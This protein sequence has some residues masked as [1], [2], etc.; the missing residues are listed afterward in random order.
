MP[1]AIVIRAAGTNCDSEMVRAFRLAG[2]SCDLVHVDRLIDDPRRLEDYELIGFPG[3]FSFGDDVASGRIFALRLKL[4]LYPA[5]R[6]AAR[7]GA[8]MIGACNGF[9]VLTQAGLLPGPDGEWP[10]APPRQEVSLTFNEGGSFIDRWLKVE[11]DPASVCVWTRGLAERFSGS[12]GDEA[13]W[14]PIAHGEGRFVA[15]SAAVL[16]RLQRHGQVALRYGPGDNV[17]GSMDRVAGI[18][19]RSGRIFGLMPHPERYLD[20]NRHPWWTRLDA[21][22]AAGSTPGLAMF[23]NAVSA[24]SRAAAPV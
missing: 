23:A 1:N 14:L 11:P 18:C 16:D 8:L 24:A 7:R 2:A 15:E 20:W 10:D 17:N 4:H 9:Q 22:T 13:L 12:R 5:L 19:D 6:D 21:R 3:G